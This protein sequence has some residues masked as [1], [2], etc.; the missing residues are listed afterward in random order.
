MKKFTV[1]NQYR[2]HI[3]KHVNWADDK[4]KSQLPFDDQVK[5]LA[6]QR[7]CTAAT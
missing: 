4:Q 2:K 7:G 3:G 6:S 1:N 5:L